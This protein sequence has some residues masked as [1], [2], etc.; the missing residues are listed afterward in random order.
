M[1]VLGAQVTIQEAGLEGNNA[2][3]CIV[4]AMAPTLGEYSV[5]VD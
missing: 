2:V 3:L 5:H 4:F 1:T